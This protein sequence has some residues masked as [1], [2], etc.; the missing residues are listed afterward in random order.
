MTAGGRG[1]GRKRASRM[2]DQPTRQ[3]ARPDMTE[4]V[5]RETVWHCPRCEHEQE[6]SLFERDD[7]L[8]RWHAPEGGHPPALM[9]IIERERIYPSEGIRRLL[10]LMEVSDWG[11]ACQAIEHYK[12]NRQSAA[13]RNPGA[14]RVLAQSVYPRFDGSGGRSSAASGTAGARTT[15]RSAV[16]VLVVLGVM[17]AL[18][19]V[20][21][22]VLLLSTVPVP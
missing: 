6:A 19:C 14:D 3:S 2:H 22:G 15:M 4:S 20:L 1:T 21:V 12:R 7:L 5:T 17:A 8:S 11:L 18:A 13:R 16:A 10:E 9:R